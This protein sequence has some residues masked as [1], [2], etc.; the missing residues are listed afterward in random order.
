MHGPLYPDELWPCTYLPSDYGWI[1]IASVDV[2]SRRLI[3]SKWG[4]G[5]LDL[6]TSLPQ[7]LFSVALTCRETATQYD[8]SRSTL[9]SS[10]EL[11]QLGS[12]LAANLGPKLTRE[13]SVCVPAERA[14]PLPGLRRSRGPLIHVS[15]VFKEAF[16]AM[17][18]V[19]NRVPR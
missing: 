5:Y 18:F 1:R 13:S 19:E 4:M 6:V 15:W 17:L 10:L 11:F 3:R 7:Q 8:T 12:H 14:A 2:D 16:Q 9:V